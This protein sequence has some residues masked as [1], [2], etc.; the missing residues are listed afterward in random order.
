MFCGQ[1]IKINKYNKTTFAGLTGSFVIIDSFFVTVFM[2]KFGHA[3]GEWRWNPIT[4]S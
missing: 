3:C 4:A 1:K 2:T